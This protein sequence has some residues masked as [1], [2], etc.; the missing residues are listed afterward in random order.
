MALAYL[1]VGANLGD[2]WSS[3]RAAL[4]ALARDL[5]VRRV[6]SVY[7]TAPWGKLDQPAFLNCCVAVET[8]RRPR[9]LLRL[10]KDIENRLGRVPSERW[11]PR[12]VDID[13]LLYGEERVVAPDLVVPHARLTER[14]FVLVPLSEIAPDAR[15]AGTDLTVRASLARVARTPGDVVRVGALASPDAGR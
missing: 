10:A 15:I 2:R 12:A 8:E 3:L 9:E 5:T 7:E 11:G 6:S 1:G 14:A 13:V 4:D